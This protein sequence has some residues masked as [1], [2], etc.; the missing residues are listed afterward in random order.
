MT[1]PQYLRGP[2]R[3]CGPTVEYLRCD[4]CVNAVKVLSDY[5]FVR[6]NVLSACSATS[7][8]WAPLALT[9]SAVCGRFPLF[10]QHNLMDTEW[11]WLT[12]V[13][14]RSPP[15][16]GATA[17][18]Q[19]GASEESTFWL[20]A[21]SGA[22]LSQRSVLV[23]APCVL[24]KATQRILQPA[25]VRVVLGTQHRKST[26]RHQNLHHLRVGDAPLVGKSFESLVLFDLSCLS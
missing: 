18:V 4:L 2:P 3:G 21:C 13:Y 23:A 14:V 24:D 15:D 12:A 11:P 6:V 9:H 20:L 17:T 1:P 16:S 19:Q 10:S 25:Q 26:E 5:L 8:H 7:D 22:L